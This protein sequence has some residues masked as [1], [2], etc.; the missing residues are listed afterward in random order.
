MQNV[1]DNVQEVDL[2]PQAG[3]FNYMKDQLL[4]QKMIS[5]TMNGKV[6]EVPVLADF[7][8]VFTV[9]VTANPL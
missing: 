9:E 3:A 6:S 4:A 2:T 8:I 1:F 5:Y 7:K